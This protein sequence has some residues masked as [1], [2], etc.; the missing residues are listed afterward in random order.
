MGLINRDDLKLDYDWSSQPGDDP[1]KKEDVG[2][3]VFN[4]NQ[5]EDVLDLLN[6][7]AEEKDIKD[8]N[9]ILEAEGMLRNNLPKDLN[10]KNDVMDW[11]W[12]KLRKDTQPA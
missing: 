6:D 3:N 1:L 8:K 9:D 5:G 2:S 12:S 11:L 4:K 7:Y 10:T